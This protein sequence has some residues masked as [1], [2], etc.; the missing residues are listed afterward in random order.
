MRKYWMAGVA[1]AL[2]IHISVKAQDDYTIRAKKYI[3]Q[4]RE[5]AVAEQRRTGIPAAI[6]LAQGIH[7]T[8]AGISPLAVEANNHFGI[9]CKK[10]WQGATY[11]YTDDAPDEC[12]RKYSSP[13][14]SYKD[15]SDYLSHTPRY[16]SLF[17]LTS[18]DY[19][20]WAIGLKQAGY[21]TNPRYAQVLIKIIEDYHLQEYTYAALDNN[22]LEKPAGEVIPA[23]D[24]KPVQEEPWATQKEKSKIKV[25]QLAAATETPVQPEIQPAFPPY[26]QV[27]KV[28][29]LKA[30]YARKGD[31]P[32]EYAI[33]QNIRYERLLEINEISDR[34][35]A[36]DMY[37]YLERKRFKGMR[38]THTVKAGETLAK[39]AQ[40]EGMQAKYLRS[41]NGLQ[42][43]EEPAEGSV[44]YL[45]ENAPAKPAVANV[46]GTPAPTEAKETAI[47]TVAQPV[48]EQAAIP[49][50]TAE[51]TTAAN[52]TTQEP[53]VQFA[54]QKTVSALPEANEIAKAEIGPTHMAEPQEQEHNTAGQETALPQPMPATTV[55]AQPETT[56]PVTVAPPYNIANEKPVEEEIS[57][58]KAKEAKPQPEEPKDELDALKAKFDKVVYAPKPAPVKAEEPAPAPETPATSVAEEPKTQLQASSAGP[59]FYTVKKG[60]TAF[61]IAKRNNIT[62][63]QLMELNKMD[64][65]EIKIGQKLRVKP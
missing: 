9:K 16:A 55:A 48:T 36:E 54:D 21:A 27:V 30:V 3:E 22:I 7:E 46:P 52:T 63:R 19:A 45:Q 60:D 58:T 41:L 64:F 59:K 44:L 32:L 56:G 40:Y 24:A 61:N 14:E 57:A 15:H 28:N 29:G 20:S 53:Q 42:E 6:T 38:P 1:L 35:L 43:N 11:T 23:Q 17:K 26:G 65:E 49:A 25:E 12:F 18:T 50:T 13:E 33:N 51:V 62:V 34:P 4:F 47:I 10:T 39:V 5:L 2:C 37:L 8:A 31:M